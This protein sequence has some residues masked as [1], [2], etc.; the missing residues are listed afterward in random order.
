M[1]LRLYAYTD[2]HHEVGFSLL[3]INF[4]GKTSYIIRWVF[5]LSVYQ[6]LKVISWVLSFFFFF[7]I[8]ELWAIFV[9]LTRNKR[10]QKLERFHYI[11][12]FSCLNKLLKNK[13]AL[14]PIMFITLKNTH[15]CTHTGR[16]HFNSFIDI[17]LMTL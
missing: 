1:F 13:S 11:F 10:S 15:R 8:N 6:W 7:F 4:T 9:L 2:L 3:E 12:V 5:H 16:R 14:L 17:I